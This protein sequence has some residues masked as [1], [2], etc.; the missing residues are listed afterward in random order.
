[1]ILL[2]FFL[3]VVAAEADLHRLLR[4]AVAAVLVGY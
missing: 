2:R 4:L 3:L 1:V